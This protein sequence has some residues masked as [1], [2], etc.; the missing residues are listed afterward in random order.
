MLNLSTVAH[1]FVDIA[2]GRNIPQTEVKCLLIA[3]GFSV[4]DKDNREGK[5]CYSNAVTG[6]AKM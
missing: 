1:G 6:T 3:D 2:I 5:T 4:P